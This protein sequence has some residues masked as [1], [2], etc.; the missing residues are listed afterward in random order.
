MSVA[1]EAEVAQLAQ[2]A[3]PPLR[4]KHPY[5]TMEWAAQQQ[6]WMVFAD[7]PRR[8]AAV[9]QA[10]LSVRS[11]PPPQ[12]LTVLHLQSDE[13]QGWLTTAATTGTPYPVVGTL[14]FHDMRV[15]SR[16]LHPFLRYPWEAQS[17]WLNSVTAPIITPW[18][19]AMAQEMLSLRSES[20]ARLLTILHPT[21]EE[22]QGWLS[23]IASVNV[24]ALA[25]GI[26]QLR[27]DLQTDLRPKNGVLI[28]PS[29][30]QMGWLWTLLDATTTA[31]IPAFGQAS[32]SVRS[33][34]RP[35]QLSLFQPPLEPEQGWIWKVVD[36]IV[37]TWMPAMAQELRAV[38]SDKPLRPLL[39]VY[40]PWEEQGWLQGAADATLRLWMPAAGQLLGVSGSRVLPI[41]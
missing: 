5:T 19:P 15:E 8:Q 14:G 25:A 23:T 29:E 27:N 10:V 38:S 41:P 21:W 36:T 2:D 31:W 34:P 13:Q 9:S 22:Q 35:P 20:P 18:L 3:M 1:S 16:P 28:L 6:G 26:L 24:P 12:P 33:A 30:S 32:L 17:G 39:V 40:P 7:V 37:Q 4:P 11:T